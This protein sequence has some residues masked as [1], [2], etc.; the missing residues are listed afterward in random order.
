MKTEMKIGVLIQPYGNHPAAWLVADAPDGAE[1]DIG[2]Y[3]DVA[4]TAESG[5]LDFVFFADV[6]AIRNGNLHAISK[7][8]LYANQFE[9]VTLLAALSAATNRIGLAA[10]VST[11]FYEPYNL[12]RQFA[13][14]DHLSRGRAAWNVVT[15]SQEA[16]ALNFGGD[17]RAG[18]AAR[19]ERA[20]EFI[21]VVKGL[22]DSWDDDAF[23]YDRA[24]STFFDPA[25]LRRL[26]HAGKHFSVRGPLNIARPPQGYPVIV[27]A[28]GSEAGKALAAE[29][30]ELVFSS[31]AELERAQRFYADLKGRLEAFGR[32]RDDLKIVSALNPIVGRT[33]GEAE[34]KL[35]RLQEKLHPDVGR[36]ILAID[37]DN[38][39]LSDL[40]VDA[41]LPL[42]RIPASTEG[43][44]SY[45][46]Y[47]RAMSEEGTL[48]LRT[49]YEKYAVAR[50]GKFIVGTAEEIADEMQEWFEQGA[51]DGFML[52]MSSLPDGLQDFVT[53]VIPELRRRGLFRAGY[54][55]STLREHLGLPRPRVQQRRGAA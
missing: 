24:T 49:L 5:A 51:C 25:R 21:D 53:L 45:L 37:L 17:A 10:T 35:A 34:E 13:S 2:H 48:T 38:I 32:S 16:A 20:K 54:S 3:I 22:W 44:K 36:E 46:E 28:G 40:S 33:R 7:W 8:P 55:G 12:A 4:R 6:P 18:H 11:S 27:Q 19:Y 50:G 14:I 39:D 26:D 29:T 31:E 23:V 52:G 9:P 42:D 15:T 47:I 43:G 1:N 41:P 30:A